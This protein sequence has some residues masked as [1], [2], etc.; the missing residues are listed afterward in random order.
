MCQAKRRSQLL[1]PNAIAPDSG[2]SKEPPLQECLLALRLGNHAKQKR[3]FLAP[4]Q[5]KGIKTVAAALISV[6]NCGTTALQDAFSHC[7]L[8]LGN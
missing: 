2:T 8:T 4:T 6:A 3:E 7:F 1:V 5:A